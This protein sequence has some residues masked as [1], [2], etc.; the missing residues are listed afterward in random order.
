MVAGKRDNKYNYQTLNGNP[1]E[2][3]KSNNRTNREEIEYKPIPSGPVT[4]ALSNV[5]IRVLV[6]IVMPSRAAA[7]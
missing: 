5:L 1:P 4:A 2:L 6:Y 7:G 3:S